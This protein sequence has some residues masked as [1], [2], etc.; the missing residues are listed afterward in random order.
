M[1]LALLRIAFMFSWGNIFLSFIVFILVLR[2]RFLVFDCSMLNGIKRKIYLLFVCWSTVFEIVHSLVVF[3]CILNVVD[4]ISVIS[5]ILFY[6]LEELL[7]VRPCL[8]WASCPHK[9]LDFAP[10]FSVDFQG[11]NKLRMLF[12]LPSSGWESMPSSVF[13]Y[14]RRCKSSEVWWFRFISISG[15]AI[16]LINL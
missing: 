15:S 11:L 8:C 10:I 14:L 12:F 13:V 7:G 3:I 6:L 1:F 5:E 9:S 16:R 4:N 2:V